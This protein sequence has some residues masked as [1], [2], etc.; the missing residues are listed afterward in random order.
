[1]VRKSPK[2]RPVL[3]RLRPTVDTALI[4]LHLHNARGDVVAA[5][6]LP[7]LDPGERL[8]VLNWVGF[9]PVL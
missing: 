8:A 2:T 3:S 9:P 6:P 5:E 1:M 7:E 4:R